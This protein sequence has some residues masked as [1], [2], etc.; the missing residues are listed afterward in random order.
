MEGMEA[1]EARMPWL[2]RP[3]FCSL[4]QNLCRLIR[5]RE[6]QARRPS[7]GFV[8]SCDSTA[9]RWTLCR[10]RRGSH[11]EVAACHVWNDVAVSVRYSVWALVHNQH[12]DHESDEAAVP[13]SGTG[14]KPRNYYMVLQFTCTPDSSSARSQWIWHCHDHVASKRPFICSLPRRSLIQRRPP[15]QTQPNP[16]PSRRKGKS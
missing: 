3:I 5:H 12:R 8:V 2:V 14:G 11:G 15:I 9:V 1:D 4:Y 10:P 16:I 7:K 6:Y 13:S